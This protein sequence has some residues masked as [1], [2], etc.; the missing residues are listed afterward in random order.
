MKVC[1]DIYGESIR[2]KKKERYNHDC[3]AV[4][5]LPLWNLYL[6]FIVFRFR[7]VTLCTT[8]QLSTNT[9]AKCNS[10]SARTNCR[11]LPVGIILTSNITHWN[12]TFVQCISPVQILH[13]SSTNLQCKSHISPV[14]PYPVRL[15]K[16][17]IFATEIWDLHWRNARFALEKCEI[18][19]GEMWDLHRKS[20]RNMRFTLKKCVISM[21][22]VWSENDPNRQLL[23]SSCRD[24]VTCCSSVSAGML[25][26]RV[27][28]KVTR[29]D[30]KMMKAR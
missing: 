11:Y 3:H 13:F 27:V 1:V 5:D 22:D 14:L 12:Y 25:S 26:C 24:R 18:C 19:T 8:L 20:V 29:P 17:E 10:I 6:A 15:S 7:R 16:C 28:H 4:T 9:T 2:Q 23:V 21:C 30:L